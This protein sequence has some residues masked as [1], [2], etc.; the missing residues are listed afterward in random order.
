MAKTEESV[1][2]VA[3]AK[4]HGVKKLRTI[5]VTP[6][7]GEPFDL[8]FKPID[9]RVYGAMAS[10][11]NTDPV[12]AVEIA[13][14]TLCISDNKDEVLGDDEMLMGLAG[15]VAEMMGT[16]TASLKKS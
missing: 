5:T 13:V 16:V 3:L 1:D 2:L 15:A 14:S 12:G 11:Y 9:R 10:M 6:E 4:Q 7:D 8:I